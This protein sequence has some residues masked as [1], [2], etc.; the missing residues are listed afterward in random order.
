MVSPSS[1][2]SGDHASRPLRL[3]LIVGGCGLGAGLLVAGLAAWADGPVSAA[4]HDAGIDLALRR[5]GG[6]PRGLSEV[7]KT[8]G[9]WYFALAVAVVIGLT[10]ARKLWAGLFVAACALSASSNAILKWVAGRQRPFREGD[11]HADPHTWDLFRNGIAFWEQ[12]N[13]SF[14]SGHAT[15]AFALATAVI[16]LCR[17]RWGGWAYLALIPAAATAA[18]RVLS[19]SHYLSEV[20]A[21]GVLGVGGALAVLGLF[22]MG[23]RRAA[24][25]SPGALDRDGGPGA[26]A[27]RPGPDGHAG[28][29]PV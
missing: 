23:E 7:L 6:W 19:N 29:D 2:P 4:V 22:R 20:T 12:T 25:G 5:K 28:Q 26:G 9:E 16:V 27:A 3:G 21:G 14:P 10:H 18:E 15:H 13:L 1:L 17:A 11:F 8:P 24:L